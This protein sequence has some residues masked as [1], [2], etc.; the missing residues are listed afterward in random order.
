MKR[1]L[2]TLL[3]LVCLS[4]C[5]TWQ[6][7]KAIRDWYM[8]RPQEMDVKPKYGYYRFMHGVCDM[9]GDR[10]KL[11]VHHIK[12]QHIA[13]ELVEVESNLTTLCRECHFVVGHLRNWKAWNEGVAEA[14]KT[15]K[16]CQ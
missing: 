8:S 1:M 13:P 2:T 7:D 15:R 16:Y 3:M 6:P 12:P 5:A 10:D 4:G 9:C 14:I 11:E